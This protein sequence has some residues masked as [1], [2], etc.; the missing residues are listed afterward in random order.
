M[1]LSDCYHTRKRFIKA[2][3]EPNPKAT[4]PRHVYSRAAGEQTVLFSM[5]T[6]RSTVLDDVASRLWRVLESRPDLAC[7][8]GELLA[9]GVDVDQALKRIQQLA[10]EKLLEI[11]E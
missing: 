6:M 7:P 9:A 11:R 4:I 5:L 2:M 8:I 10:G 1:A 3:P